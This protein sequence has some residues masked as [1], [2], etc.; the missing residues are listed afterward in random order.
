MSLESM[1]DYCCDEC[2]ATYNTKSAKW[3]DPVVPESQENNGII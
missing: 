3:T 2:G 1:I